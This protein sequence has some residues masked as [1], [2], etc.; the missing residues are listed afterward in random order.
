MGWMGGVCPVRVLALL[1]SL[2]LSLP[3]GGLRLTLTAE[4]SDLLSAGALSG[5]QSVLSGMAL[6]LAAD[7]AEVIYGDELLLAARPGFLFTDD[8]SAPQPVE[9]VPDLETLWNILEPWKAEKEETADLQEAGK[10][11]SQ[12]VY[13]LTAE[14]WAALGFPGKIAEK[15]T[16]KRY[17]DGNGQPLGAYFYTASL[18][19]EEQTR[20]V[21]LE[22][23]YRAEKGLYLAF[24]CPDEAQK[25]NLRISLHGRKTASGWTLEGEL[26][27]G[28]DGET[29]VYAVKGSTAG[30]LTLTGNEKIKGRTVK[31]TLTLTRSQDGAEYRLAKGDDLTLA[32]RVT[33]EAAELP[34]RPIPDTE[35]NITEALAAH[36][37]A[38][39][40]AAAPESWQ[41]LVHYLT[42]E[43]LIDAQKKGE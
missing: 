18:Q 8:L 23:G 19:T 24:R 20:E 36:L 42:V 11:R 10:A 32:G 39:L 4:K 14:D 33:W 3:A 17:F 27:R 16:F 7:G 31:R 35:G 25:N 34:D 9:A 38:I 29:T 30:K 22:Y 15:A 28:A 40:R 2:F 37:A 1:L 21:R 5:L 12:A 41:Q 6:T 26:R 43:T 13:I